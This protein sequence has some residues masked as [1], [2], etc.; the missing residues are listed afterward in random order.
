MVAELLMAEN[1]LKFV[2]RHLLQLS[3]GHKETCEKKVEPTAALST[4]KSTAMIE[5][6]HHRSKSA[7]VITPVGLT[8]RRKRSRTGSGSIHNDRV[9]MELEKSFL[10]EGRERGLETEVDLKNEGTTNHGQNQLV[11]MIHGLQKLAEKTS[12]V[13]SRALR[14]SVKHLPIRF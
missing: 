2:K 13:A 12:L 1:W 14:V 6:G 7:I 5:K 10:G 3:R 4:S 8:D 9:E 11:E